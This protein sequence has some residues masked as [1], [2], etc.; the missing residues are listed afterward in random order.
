MIPEDYPLWSFA[1]H[2]AALERRSRART[3]SRGGTC[4]GGWTGSE[5][6][7]RNAPVGFI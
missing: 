7:D 1:V 4:A 3:P 5:P 2:Q 6:H